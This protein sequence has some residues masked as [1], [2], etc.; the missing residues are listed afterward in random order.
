MEACSPAR[1]RQGTY[2]WNL[3]VELV[4]G[5]SL[6]GL[7]WLRPSLRSTVQ[8]STMPKTK[9]LPATPGRPPASD[10]KN[11]DNTHTSND[12]T[13]RAQNR[14]A[15]GKK[16]GLVT[17]SAL[18]VQQLGLLVFVFG[19]FLTRF[20]MPHVSMCN[21][22]LGNGTGIRATGNNDHGCW[23][24]RRYDK[25]IVVV[26]DALRLDFAYSVPSIE[27]NQVGQKTLKTSCLLPIGLAPPFQHVP[28]FVLESP[29]FSPRVF[30][31][32]LCVHRQRF[33]RN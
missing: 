28:R 24:P 9:S 16:S 18:I 23:H 31:C 30:V 26:I 2:G 6:S 3:G 29:V 33:A 12:G 14:Y 13:S 25:A 15:A 27:N 19:F 20:E 11:N 10:I 1:W 4:L 32:S 17:A 5:L 7:A 22:T 21:D 8:P